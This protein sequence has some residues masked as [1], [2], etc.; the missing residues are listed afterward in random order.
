MNENTCILAPQAKI[1]SIWQLIIFIQHGRYNGKSS[2]CD[3]GKQNHVP[4]TYLTTNLLNQYS[5]QFKITWKG[6]FIL[7]VSQIQKTCSIHDFRCRKRQTIM[8]GYYTQPGGYRDCSSY[9]L[10]SL[11]VGT[12]FNFLPC[13]VIG[14]FA[15]NVR[16]R[17]KRHAQTRIKHRIGGQKWDVVN[18]DKRRNLVATVYLILNVTKAVKKHT[19]QT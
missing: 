6:L 17:N 12:L 15:T 4:N 1:N 2:I 13:K 10:A 14:G 16:H 7:S 3:N 11:P 19:S 9:R 18:C 5:D 8:P